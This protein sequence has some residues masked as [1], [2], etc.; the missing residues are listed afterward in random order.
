MSVKKLLLA[1][2]LSCS[3]G[4]TYVNNTAKS[5]SSISKK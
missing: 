3:V 4:V 2:L 1:M 5:T